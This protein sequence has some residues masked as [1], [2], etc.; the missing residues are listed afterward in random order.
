[1][2]KRILLTDD[3]IEHYGFKPYSIDS[4]ELY[5]FKVSRKISSTGKAFFFC[6]NSKKIVKYI[7][8]LKFK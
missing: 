1:M 6:E 2:A 8:Q 7:D 3:Y 5:G 4:W